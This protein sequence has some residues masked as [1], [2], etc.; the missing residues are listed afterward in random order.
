MSIHDAPHKIHTPHLYIQIKMLSVQ[1]I[2]TIQYKI[3]INRGKSKSL[4]P[5]GIIYDYNR[6]RMKHLKTIDN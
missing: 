1:Y 6:G 4:G 2:H 5:I 3:V